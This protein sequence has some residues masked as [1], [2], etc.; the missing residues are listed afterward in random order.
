MNSDQRPDSFEVVDYTHVLRRRWPIV[1]VVTIICL[2]GAVGYTYAG[3]KAYTATAQVYVAATGADLAAAAAEGHSASGALNLDTEAQIVAS[4]TVATLAGKKMHSSLSSYDLSKDVAV[5]VPA[6]SQLM[7]IAC[8]MSSATAAASCANAFA[9]AYLEN[10]S[11]DAASYI[12]DQI[13][14]LKSQISSLQKTVSSLNTTIQSQPKNSSTRATDQSQ[15]TSDN[16][17]L[18]NLNSKLA[19]LYSEASQS[20]GGNITTAAG[21]PGSPS[22]PKK[23]LVLPS[24]LA[25]GLVIGLIAA[26][27]WDRRDKRIHDSRDAGRFLSLPIL[28]DLPK[29]S[30]GRQV[31]LASPRSRTGKAFTEMAHALGASLGE[32]SHVVLVAGTVPGSGASLVAANLAASLA[33]THSEAVLVCAALRDSIAPELFGL[34]GDGRGLAEVV[35]GRA[36]VGEVAR[37]PAS[38]P[39]LWVIPPGA[40]PALAEYNLQHDMAKAMTSQLRRDA[41]FVVIEAQAT[42]DGAETFSLAEFADAAVLTVELSRTTR[43]EASGCIERLHR[44]RTPVAGVAVLPAVPRKV[45]VRPPQG[46]RGGDDRRSVQSGPGSDGSQTGR[47][48]VSALTG[49]PGNRQQPGGR[50]DRY[51]NAADHT[52]ES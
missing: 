4:G 33:R 48:A 29:R 27:V 38:A 31:A 39:G 44:M 23:S 21:V 40:D 26:F 1:V 52:P 3:P 37:G 32:G 45:D 14:P 22:S 8:S 10:R 17:Q 46:G 49:T 20:N 5:S 9:A 42:E 24:G 28:L 50:S 13:T 25:A 41:R 47:G 30:I 43:D 6:N 19:S 11:A 18:S 15:M 35:A 7:D 16:N 34:A 36:T 12:N 2:I 51:G